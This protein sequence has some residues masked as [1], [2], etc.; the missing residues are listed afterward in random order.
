MRHINDSVADSLYY[1]CY[2]YVGLWFTIN[3]CNCIYRVHLVCVYIH[4]NTHANANDGRNSSKQIQ[5]NMFE[6]ISDTEIVPRIPDIH[7]I[8]NKIHIQF[9]PN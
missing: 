1:Y 5:I 9:E 8:C 4:A 3:K 6:S 7:A 2:Y